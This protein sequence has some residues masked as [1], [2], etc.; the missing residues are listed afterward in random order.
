MVEV[1]IVPS[2]RPK[3]CPICPPIA[4]LPNIITSIN[5]RSPDHSEVV[6]K[7]KTIIVAKGWVLKRSILIREGVLWITL[8]YA[9]LSV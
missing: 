6:R 1:Y 3:L 4:P 7:A 2:R 8:L 9:K 5:I